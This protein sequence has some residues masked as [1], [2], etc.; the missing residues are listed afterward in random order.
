MTRQWVPCCDWRR[1]QRW[2]ILLFGT[3]WLTAFVSSGSVRA[4]AVIDVN[5]TLLNIIQNTSAALV[6]GPPEVAREIA[7]IDGA[8]F[9]AVNASSG[10]PYPPIAYNGGPVS[11]ADRNAAALRAALTVMNSLYG[12]SSLYQQYEGVTGATYY[13]SIPPYANALVGPTV[14]QMSQVAAQISIIRAKLAALGSSP[15]VTAGISLG[16]AVGNAMLAVAAN[17]GG[18]AA[19]LQTLT[20]YVPPNEGNPGVYVP[21]SNRP[22]MTPTWG[23]VQPIGISSVTLAGL[24]AT[25][26]VAYAATSQGLTSQT[27]SLQV[28]QTECQGSGTGLPSNVAIA[29][30]ATGFAPASAAE[31]QAALFWNDPGGTLQPPG[32]WL[33]I[34]DTIAIQ[35]ELDLLDTAR[36]TAMVGLALHAAGIGAWAT[37][38]EDVAWRPVTAIQDC[39][40]WSPNFTRCDSIWSSLIA[41]P[42]HPDYL[43]GHPAFS[44]VA[45]T[46]LATVLGSDSVTFTS[47]SNA[48]CNAGSTTRDSLGNVVSCTLNGTTYSMA[49]AGCANGGTLVYDTTGTVTGCTLNGIPQ[50]V[51]GGGC[52]NAGLVSVLNS[53]YTANRAYNGSP[54]I[55]PIAETYTSL[56]QASGG[57]LGAEFSRVAGGIHTPAAVVQAL[58]LGNAIG[59]FIVPVALTSGQSCNGNYNGVF[60]GNVTVSAGQNCVLT[61]PC[62]IKG[63]V[64]VT[65]GSFALACTVDRNVTISGSGAFS[66]H[67]ASIGNNLHIQSLS[68]GQPPGTVCGSMIKGN[69][70]VQ[71]NASPVEIGAN[72]AN[73]C[74]GNT[75]RNNLQVRNN[76]AS[77]SIDYN[78]VSGNLQVNNDT[79]TTDVSGNMVGNNLLC[80]NNTPAV[81]HIALNMVQ[82]QAQGQCAAAP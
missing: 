39:T 21:P 55:C 49:T 36:A 62:E 57:F 51:I 69:L 64:N 41:T 46:A 6:D 2:G 18:H 20:P 29:C 26:P 59:S 30:R 13:P 42:P 79:A 31:A 80:R 22:A 71:N 54:L 35:E 81:T 48:Y 4:N 74:A 15:L 52:N 61:S 23:S 40:A 28:L 47:T 14:A 44:G 19:S 65:G 58:A 75:V 17:D 53:D 27:Y 37:K 25:V 50:T 38:Y 72:N 24:K 16:T 8:M 78:N 73:A 7:L 10:N 66:L 76:S 9:D 11:G 82:G 60:N 67:G 77:T 45:A 5:N 33:Q 68:A 56:S 43:A 12:P 70:V 1:L 32:H 63:D 3:V 34:A